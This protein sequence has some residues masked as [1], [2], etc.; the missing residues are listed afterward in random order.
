MHQRLHEG[1]C[2]S[3]GFLRVR[4]AVS[5]TLPQ[6][7]LLYSEARGENM[8][9]RYLVMSWQNFPMGYVSM[10]DSIFDRLIE[11]FGLEK[12]SKIIKSNR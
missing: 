3:Q 5:P 11:S 6:H 2:A 12:T 1:Q 4:Q 7:H 9:M 8:E 10:L